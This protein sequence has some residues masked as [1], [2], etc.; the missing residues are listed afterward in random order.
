MSSKYARIKEISEFTQLKERTIRSYV[1]RREIPFL[2][3]K[4]CLVFDIQ[5]I[6][7][8]MKMHSFQPSEKQ[9]RI[10]DGGIE[11]K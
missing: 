9:T 2:K 6:D 3:I 11:R 8:W 5:A 4:G 7:A 10:G 1:Q